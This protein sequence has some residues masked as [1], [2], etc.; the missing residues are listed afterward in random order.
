M[1]VASGLGFAIGPPI[2][3]L[4]YGVSEF[5]PVIDAVLRFITLSLSSP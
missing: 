1:E 3:G 2:G 5:Y 4:L